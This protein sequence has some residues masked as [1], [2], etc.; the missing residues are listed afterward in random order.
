MQCKHKQ[1]ECDGKW[2]DTSHQCLKA[3]QKHPISVWHRFG[4]NSMCLPI[5]CFARTC[6]SNTFEDHCLSNA[7]PFHLVGN[8]WKVCF[9]LHKMKRILLLFLCQKRVGL[10]RS[11]RNNTH[12]HNA[13]PFLG[14][15]W[16][17]KQKWFE[18]ELFQKSKCQFLV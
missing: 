7:W 17:M 14:R 18:M 10:V 5:V 16:T 15:T 6:S 2:V 11:K 13:I 3:R 12:L 9:F 1:K 8:I 4:S